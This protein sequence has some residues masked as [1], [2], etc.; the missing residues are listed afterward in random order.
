[1]HDPCR[2]VMRFVALFVILLAACSAPPPASP[3]SPTFNWWLKDNTA[4]TQVDVNPGDSVHINGSHDFQVGV[5]VNGASGIRYYNAVAIA[6]QIQCGRAAAKKTGAKSG[7]DGQ[8]IDGVLKQ[9]TYT[10]PPP[11][12]MAPPVQAT[13]FGF[14][15]A[16]QPK[17]TLCPRSAP[18]G[19]QVLFVVYASPAQGETSS[20]RTGVLTVMLD[21]V[22]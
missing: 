21:P 18:L 8:P 4:N 5:H 3:A 17:S 9:Y 11:P 12:A 14:N 20:A 16:G 7:A 19:G 1:M 2:Y 10:A 15:T 13:V 6:V 22:Q